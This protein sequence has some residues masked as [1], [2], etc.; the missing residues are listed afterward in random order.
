MDK[1]TKQTLSDLLD[2]LEKELSMCCGVVANKPEI[3]A[4]YRKIREVVDG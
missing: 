3:K 2:T 1:E 4:T